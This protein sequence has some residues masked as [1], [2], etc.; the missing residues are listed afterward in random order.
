M[1]QFTYVIKDSA[2]LHARPAG[3]LVK[4]ASAYSSNIILKIREKS[5]D[6]H[7]IFAVLALGAKKGD[8]ITVQIDGPDEKNVLNDLKAFFESYL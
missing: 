4:K 6:I 8:T 2:G 7:R 1:E 3:L 5:A